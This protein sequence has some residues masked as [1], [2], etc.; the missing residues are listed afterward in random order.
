MHAPA[1]Q[2]RQI[3]GHA[4]PILVAQLASM[5]MMV[6]DTV[7]LGHHSTVDLAAVAVGGGIYIAVVFALVGILQA[8]AP[9]VTHHVGARRHG[10]IAGTLQQAVWLG[11]LLA[12]PGILLLCFPDPILRLS[13]IEPEVEATLR[14]YLRVLAWGMPAALLYRTFYSFC[15]ALR[16]PRPL[17][18]ISFG[19]TLIHAALASQ[20]VNGTFGA[21]LGAIG[22]G[23]SNVLVNWLAC[24]AAALWIARA[25][26]L[27]AVK[28]F[29]NWQPPRLGAMRE[30]LRLGLPMGFSNFV[31]I[32]SFTLI[33]LFVAQLGATAVAGHRIVANLAAICYMLPLALAIATLALVGQAA[34][35][36]DWSRARAAIKSGM[37]LA[38]GLS[39]LTGGLLW[40]SARPLVFTYSSDPAVRAIAL[41]L[42]GYIAIY[43]FFDAV[44]TIAAYALRGYKITLAPMLVH[45]LAF[46]GIGLGGGWWLAF[47][48]P[49]PMGVEGFWLASLLSLV[50]AAL[51]I[52]SILL[53]VWR[54]KAD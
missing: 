24:A 45:I 39:T 37:L 18:L 11:L 22:C 51:A 20:L 14:A 50:V 42:I 10:E 33:A 15:N 29:A 32:T 13:T 28:A 34:G 30:L 9:I 49:E 17:M 47:R 6:I 35:A 12:V 5:G 19:N 53:W 52:G 38:A 8:V 1:S 31:E 3:I 36:R 23:I 2:T 25:P 54:R 26:A 16:Q 46:W 43:Q 40:L 44:Q 27:A 21:P 7:L 48:L 4:W 41:S